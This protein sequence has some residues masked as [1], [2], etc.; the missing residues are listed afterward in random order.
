MVE[1]TAV[2]CIH[3]DK[4]NNSVN[5]II[6]KEEEREDP[7]RELQFS[8]QLKSKS[9]STYYSVSTC[10]PATPRY[11]TY[12][13][14]FSTRILQEI[15]QLQGS[16][17]AGSFQQLFLV[18]PS[19]LHGR[20]RPLAPLQVFQGHT[21]QADFQLILPVETAFQAAASIHTAPTV[22]PRCIP[23]EFYQEK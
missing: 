12:R 11:S 13:I 20:I 6:S 22:A 17:R 15:L 23:T 21:A 18:S 3:P 4:Y 14:N 16:S 1:S 19:I 5:R 2:S 8:F 10:N 7:R 9:V